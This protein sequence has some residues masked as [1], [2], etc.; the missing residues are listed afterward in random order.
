MATRRWL[1]I[2]LAVSFNAAAAQG[3]TAAPNQ[4]LTTGSAGLKGLV[5]GVASG[6]KVRFVKYSQLPA[7]VR[8]GVNAMFAA[9]PA[10]AS[11]CTHENH[12]SF[13][14]ATCQNGAWICAAVH[15]S[16]GLT[17]GHC[18]NGSTGQRWSYP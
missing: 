9:S 2:V 17:A 14:V 12:G 15:T 1:A 4:A 8:N 18:V 10:A 3:D 11:G 7:P 5:V 16:D 13:H 6:T